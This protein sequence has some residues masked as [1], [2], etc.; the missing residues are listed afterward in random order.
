MEIILFIAFWTLCIYS[1]IWVLPNILAR[2]MLNEA[3]Q[4][5]SLEAL[6]IKPIVFD[7]GPYEYEVVDG[8]RRVFKIKVMSEG[9]KAMDGWAY[10]NRSYRGTRGVNLNIPDSYPEDNW[11]K[12]RK[13]Q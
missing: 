5:K 6:S 9:G 1:L 12:R 8:R 10:V 3:L 13:D 4:E 11:L 7:K 2:R